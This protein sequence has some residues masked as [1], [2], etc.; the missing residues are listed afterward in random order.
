MEFV[1]EN[2]PRRN[3]HDDLDQLLEENG[4]E[5]RKGAGVAKEGQE[6]ESPSKKKVAFTDKGSG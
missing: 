5:E 3:I 4:S 6:L 2:L 1:D